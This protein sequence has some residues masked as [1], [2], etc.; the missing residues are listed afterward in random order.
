[1]CRSVADDGIMNQ[2]AQ[3]E[4]YACLDWQPTAAFRTRCSGAMVA[5][6][7]P[8]SRALHRYRSVSLG[9]LLQ[10]HNIT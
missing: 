6:G 4:L 5:Y 10:Y 8:A 9:A 1:M 7:S 2:E 3:L